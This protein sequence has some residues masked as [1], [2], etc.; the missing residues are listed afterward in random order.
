AAGNRTSTII[1]GMTTVYV[2]N[3]LN[4]Y[5][6]VGTTTYAYDANGNLIRTTDGGVTTN[7]SYDVQN[8]LVGISVPGDTWTY[9]YDAFGSQVAA[10]H[11]GQTTQYL[12]DPVGL[13]NVVGQFDGVG[14]LLAH[15]TYGLGLVSHVDAANVAAFYNFDAAGNTVALTSPAGAVVNS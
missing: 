12:I 3:N 4:Q 10:T 11:H 13:G 9:Q 14:N 1:N 8:Q 15:Y 2:T 7:Y 6:L 5:T